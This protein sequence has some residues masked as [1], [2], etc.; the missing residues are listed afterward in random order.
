MSCAHCETAVREELED[1]DGI[2]EVRVSASSGRLEV[3]PQPDAPVAD[4]AVEA[5][6][7]E[8][9]YTAVRAA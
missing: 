7:E 6:V 9:G 4:A 3:T 1:V 5:A 2:A 8:V